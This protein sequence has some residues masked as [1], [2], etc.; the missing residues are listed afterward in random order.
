MKA[1][2]DRLMI[3]RGLDAIVVFGGET[4]S[5]PHAY[6]TRGAHVTG[7]Y[8]I[9]V[10]G[11]DPLLFVNPMET[12]EALVSGLTVH[13]YNEFGWADVVREHQGDRARAEVVM[14][15]R[16][17]ARAGV[18]SGR[19][20]LYGD[21]AINAAIELARLLRETYPEI[22]FAGELGMTLFDEAY[23]TKDADEIARLRAIGERTSLVVSQTWDFIAAHRAEGDTVVRPDGT[24]LTIGDVKRFVRRA[25]LDQDLEDTAMIF[26][27]GRDAGF[28]HSR[29]EA[30]QAL[31]TGQSI[32]FD[33]FPREIGGGLFHDMTRTWCI[34]HAPPDVQTT[35]D[36][37]MDAFDVAVDSFRLNMP[38]ARL[39]EAVQDYFESHGHPTGRSHPGTTDGYVHSLGH[40][41]GLNI[42]ERPGIG[43]LSKDLLGAGSVITIEPG[44]YYP[45]RGFGVRIEDSFV[46]DAD[47]SLVSLTP[48]HKELVLPLR[49]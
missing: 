4:F 35:Y 32:V 8:V 28:P 15:G 37:V 46:I 49:G 13:S 38:A 42:H 12:E 43:H 17:L 25:L 41:I 47:G 31:K 10:R 11:A 27:Q 5:A 7:G 3:A 34:G 39:Q 19:V 1:D 16:Y 6:L 33:L 45:D 18:T 48:F 22:E 29:G 9:K 30:G 20:G 26:A 36:Q 44:L 24:P 2:L 14:L 23:V 40:G 21:G